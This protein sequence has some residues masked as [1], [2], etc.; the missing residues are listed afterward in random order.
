MSDMDEV[1]DRLSG[2]VLLELCPAVAVEVGRQRVIVDGRPV[3]LTHIECE[4]LCVLSDH[5]PF[6]VSYEEL[7]ES[8][9]GTTAPAPRRLSVIISRLRAKLGS[10]REAVRTH[11][12]EGY[13]FHSPLSVAH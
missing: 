6:V 9:W 13:S 10:Q 12:G 7:G 8:V 4:V 2:L 5:S 1:R 11:L 3:H